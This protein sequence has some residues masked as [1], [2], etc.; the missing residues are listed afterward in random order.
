MYGADLKRSGR[1]MSG[2]AIATYALCLVG[3]LSGGWGLSCNRQVIVL[4]E[5]KF[6]I[7]YTPVWAR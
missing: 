2:P 6:S 5:T 1:A 3:S 4:T 7:R